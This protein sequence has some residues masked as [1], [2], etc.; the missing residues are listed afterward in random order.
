MKA[1]R[2]LSMCRCLKNLGDVFISCH[3]K[4]RHL[5]CLM[6]SLNGSKELGHLLYFMRSVNG[7]KGLGHFQQALIL[8]FHPV[9]FMPCALTFYDAIAA[10]CSSD[11][12]FL[13]KKEITKASGGVKRTSVLLMKKLK[14]KAVRFLSFLFV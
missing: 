9:V 6:R 2:L 12:G 4:Y 3:V 5:V 8:F 13:E 10:Y 7:G 14:K 11:S 1:E